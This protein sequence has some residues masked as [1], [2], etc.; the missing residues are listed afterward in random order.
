MTEVRR[1]N[2]YN[3]KAAGFFSWDKAGWSVVPLFLS[4]M[5]LGL[6]IYFRPHAA[7]TYSL[8]P[9]LADTEYYRE[10]LEE[11]W[12]KIHP[13]VDLIYSDYNCYDDGAPDGVDVIMYD[14]LLEQS[15]IS[16]GYLRPVD[17]QN[18]I[19]P[20]DF[21]KFTMIPAQGQSTLYGVP[22]LI[23]ADFL[24]YDLNDPVLASADSVIDIADG[25][26]D[27]L[28]RYSAYGEAVYRLDAAADISQD[29]SVTQSEAAFAGVDTG[30]SIGAI[31]EVLISKYKSENNYELARLYDEGK[32]DG[33]I[34]YS[35]NLSAI[36]N[37]LDDTGIKLISFSNNDN[38]P[39]YFCDMAGISAKAPEGKTD[40]CMDLVNLMADPSVLE[41]LTVKDGKP[42]YLLPAR[43]SSYDTI[44]EQYPLY[45]ELQEMIEGGNA[46]I[47]RAYKEFDY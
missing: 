6:L 31:R 15:M 11:E 40:I 26:E 14:S 1:D 25:G 10:I 4:L 24:I 3:R 34:G 23:C 13:D 9:Y 16:N 28:I 30:E 36:E 2:S 47:F 35:E 19:G 43:R 5:V 12:D 21:F 17:Q 8:Y 41:R 29:A 42:Q 18:I 32:A 38:I 45:G 20:E 7:V 46:V 27:I 44:K 22:V 39:L 33:F 37:R